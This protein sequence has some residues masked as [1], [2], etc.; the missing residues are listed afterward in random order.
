M[1]AE[2]GW[3]TP[4]SALAAEGK[5][6]IVN[7]IHA[8]LNATRVAR[9]VRPETI[10]GTRAALAEARRDVLSVSIAGWRHAMG[11]QQIVTGALFLELTGL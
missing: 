4:V 2:K 11:G 9:I 1:N 3:P 10:A 5:G 7:D 6:P 8:A